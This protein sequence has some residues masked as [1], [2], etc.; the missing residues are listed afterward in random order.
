MHKTIVAV[1]HFSLWFILCLVLCSCARKPVYPVAPFERGSV[2]I[3]LSALSEKKPVF[4]TFREG[5]EKGINFF[6]L[7]LNGEVQSYF[8]ACAKCYPKKKGYRQAGDRLDCR[9]CDVTYS[10]YDLKEG[11]GSCYPI[12][13]K[14][15]IEA[16]SYVIDREDLLQGGKYF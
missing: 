5:K 6:V 1:M 10:V 14:G 7:K 8:D 2:R 4:Y 12:R 11:I 13:L 9:A 15:R 3:E 16:G